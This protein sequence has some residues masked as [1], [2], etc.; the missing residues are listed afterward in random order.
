MVELIDDVVL[1]GGSTRIPCV[2]RT[3]AEFFDG[4]PLCK[5]VNPDTVVAEGAATLAGL[6]S[7]KFS[8]HEQTVSF[9]DVTLHNIGISVAS[10]ENG[11]HQ[12][13][14]VIRRN[15]QIPHCADYI[16]QTTADN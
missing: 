4:V 7:G 15:T 1:V 16:Y 9:K 12:M 14:V 13:Q 10:V 11:A 6:K 3:L 8:A 5:T 2:Q